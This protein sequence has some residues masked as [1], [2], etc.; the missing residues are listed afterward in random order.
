MIESHNPAVDELKTTMN[1]VVHEASRAGNVVRRLRD[2][3]RSGTAQLE[4]VAPSVLIA[5]ACATIRERADRHHIA[6]EL[7]AA[8]APAVT[9]DRVQVEAV[10]HNLLA[11][12]VDALK[13]RPDP[14]VVRVVAARDEPG[15]VRIAVEDNGPGIAPEILESLF[16]PFVTTKPRGTG[17]GLAISRSII[18]AHGG[19]LW[20][21]TL[22]PGSAFYFTVPM[23]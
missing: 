1:K 12:A 6:I 4:T 22:A 5:E 9:V 21:E 7:R 3:F 2:F 17:L 15:F 14:R 18:E 10:L 11:N 19:R 23:P 8:D 13:S 20:H 16:D